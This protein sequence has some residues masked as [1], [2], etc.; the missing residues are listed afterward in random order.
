[1]APSLRKGK[2]RA[3]E[4]KGRV[5]TSKKKS[6]TRIRLTQQEVIDKYIQDHQEDWE[7]K[8]EGAQQRLVDDLRS[9]WDAP[10]DTESESEQSYAEVMS[11]PGSS[12]RNTPTASSSHLPLTGSPAPTLT[13]LTRVVLDLGVAVG[14]ITTQL[15]TLAQQVMLATSTHPQAAKV[16]VACLKAWNGKGGSVE[17]RHFLAAFANYAGNE[18]DTLNDWDAINSRWIQNDERW[19]A[20]ALNL[21][22]DEARTWALP[23]LEL[24]AQGLLAFQGDYSHFIQAFLKRFAPLDTTEAA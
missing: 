17:A 20:A 14:H 1:M 8:S 2:A 11:Q 12:G 5:L 15:N 7:N 9:A 23:Y 19:I 3:E 4:L 21:M 24:L 10:S 16:A 13:D 18:G 22:E 6:R